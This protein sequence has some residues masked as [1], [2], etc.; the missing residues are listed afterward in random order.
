M[1]ETFRAGARPTAQPMTPR[2][3]QLSEQLEQCQE[4]LAAVRRENALLRQKLDALARRLF[5]VSSEALNPAQLQL[6]LQ[7]PELAAQPVVTPPASSVS[8]KPKPVAV[9]KARA[10]RSPEHLPVVEE[11]IEPEV[12]KAAPQDWRC[13]GQEVSEQLDYEPSRFL[14][15]RIIRKK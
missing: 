11:V 14:R 12:V 9:R 7:L 13:I 4:A 15:R 1:I 2:E 6:L 3:A 5:G 10:P 8:E